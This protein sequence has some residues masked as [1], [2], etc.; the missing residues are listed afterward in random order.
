MDMKIEINPDELPFIRE[1]LMKC[2][3]IALDAMD[4]HP[5]MNPKYFSK[6]D[7]EDLFKKIRY[8]FDTNPMED[9]DVKFNAICCER[10]FASGI[11][12]SN[13]PIYVDKRFPEQQKKIDD[14]E[15]E[16]EKL[17][18]DIKVN[19]L[20]LQDVAGNLIEVENK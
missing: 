6:V 12:Y 20:I 11:D 1:K 18:E 14:E 16:L 13:F 8:I 15:P 5:L 9:I 2:K 4:K 17:K 7:R 10:L 3:V 19:K